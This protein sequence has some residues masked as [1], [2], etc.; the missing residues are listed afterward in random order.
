MGG[1]GGTGGTGGTGGQQTGFLLS[2]S[3]SYEYAPYDPA[4]DRLD[5]ASTVKRP[6]RG[7]SVHLLDAGT[8]KEIAKTLAD[9][10]GAY[11]FNYK[12]IANVKLWVY[13]ETEIPSITIEDNVSGD[14]VYILESKIVNSAADAKLDVLATTGW[15]GTSYAKVREAAPFAILDAAYTASRRFLDEAVPPPQIPVLKLNWSVENRPEEGDKAFGQIGTSHF[16]PTGKELYILGKEDVDTDE[17]ESHII[18]HEWGHFFQETVGRS[19]SPGG[20]HGTGDVND[21]RLSWG[22][23]FAN[24]LSGIVLDPITIYGDSSGPQQASGFHFD[25]EVNDKAIERNPGW[26]SEETVQQIVFDLY[27]GKNEPFD[28]VSIGIDG[29]YHAM[30]DERM[31]P[32]LT[33]L[34]SFTTELKKNAPQAAADIDTLVTYYNTSAVF[35]VNA[36]QNEWAMGETHGGGVDS[37][38]P[39]YKAAPIGGMFTA[40]FTGGVNINKLSQNRYFRIAGDGLPVTVQSTS[41]SDVDLHVYHVGAIVAEA[42]NIGGDEIVTFDTTA[43]D[44]YVLV[45]QGYEMQAI[46]YTANIS[47]TH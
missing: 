33:T 46:S 34:F 20:S 35:G 9:D 27:D 3:L 28:K 12:D 13:A 8:S 19:D 24:A 14:A 37:S 42:Q 41:M 36:I 15:N 26:F 10:N 22:E 23:G 1:E 2:G 5:Y 30:V 47:V 18:V 44:A 29:I 17:F 16:D 7:A 40:A 32:A 45:V 25:V 11:S 31:T 6:I 38:L 39:L 21:P 4:M 43:G